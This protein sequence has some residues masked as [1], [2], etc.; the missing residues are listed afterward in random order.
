MGADITVNGKVEDSVLFKSSYVGNNAVIKNSIILNDVYIGDNAVIENCIV[1]SHS[2]I[3]GG[4]QH[5]GDEGRIKVVV[6][7]RERFVM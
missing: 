4:E 5:R 6:E 7:Q 1:E 3:N 2:T